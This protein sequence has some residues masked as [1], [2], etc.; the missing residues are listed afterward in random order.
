[1]I[2]LGG[3]ISMNNKQKNT[4]I[5]TKIIMGFGIIAV[6]VL[7][8]NIFMYYQQNKVSKETKDMITT[9]LHLLNLDQ[10]LSASFAVRLASARGYV[11]SGDQAEKEVFLAYTEQAKKYNDELEQ[12]HASKNAM[13]LVADSI[14]WRENVL[15]NV[16]K[17]YEEGEKVKAQKNLQNLDADANRI[18]DGF[19]KMA[20]NRFQLIEEKGQD[21][22]SINSTMKTMMIICTIALFILSLI[23]AYFT[24]NIILRPI[25]RVTERM[26]RIA[27]GDISQDDLPIK[28]HDEAG[29]L[30]VAANVVSAKLRE[31]IAAVQL[32]STQVKTASEHLAQSS[33]E[34]REGSNQIS[35]TMQELAEGTED[36]ASHATDLVQVIESFTLQVT[37]ANAGGNLIAEKA[38]EV[39]RLT[40]SGRILMDS[41]T[42]QMTS[43]DEIVKAAVEKVEFLETQSLEITK[44]VLVIQTVAEQTNLLALN[45]AIEA[46]RAGEEGRGF[47]VVA[48]EVRKLAEQVA[49]SVTDIS[50][51]VETM[52]NDT[53][54]V[55]TSLQSG[56][57]EVSKGTEQIVETAQTFDHIASAVVLMNDHANSISQSL[58]GIMKST[59]QINSSI[60]QIASVSEE[61]AA[62]VEETTATIE[63]T[64]SSMEEISNSAN[65]L[66][67]MANQLNEEVNKFKLYE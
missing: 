52:Q 2:T 53:T 11:L 30:T 5:R 48:D 62:G 36:Q 20:E 65:E 17:T 14:D 32:I 16:F 64:T 22:L 34:V 43:I 40:D 57:S 61:S 63:E 66:S 46:A 24:S 45:A 4:S 56:Y 55:T 12:Y 49:L 44:L 13:T 37:E 54:A 47:A 60:D 3:F 8:L 42:T 41:S 51:I 6:I 29:Q 59:H 67:Q 33:G 19:E 7:L 39:K 35:M 27:T 18:R 9:E 25:K 31:M 21:V 15:E 28:S 58:T 26:Q 10:Q 50:S 38:S 23:V 1:M